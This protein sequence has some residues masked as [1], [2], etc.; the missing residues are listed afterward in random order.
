[1]AINF[2][3]RTVF[4]VFHRF[5]IIMFLFS[6]VSGYFF[7]VSSLISEVYFL[8][9]L[10]K[11][12]SIDNFFLSL[13][14][15]NLSILSLK[16]LFWQRLYKF[17]IE[18]I[19]SVSIRVWFHTAEIIMTS[20]SLKIFNVKYQVSCFPDGSEVKASTCNGETWVQSLGREDPLEKEIATHSSILAWRIP[21]MEEPGGLQ[22]TRSQRV[23]HD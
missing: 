12:N 10:K 16:N 21:Q 19:L 3:H 14:N 6:L 1:M 4:A 5:W 8:A 13:P 15:T 18:K 2:P 22:S 23:R 9:Y 17:D 11:Q 7:F 20:L